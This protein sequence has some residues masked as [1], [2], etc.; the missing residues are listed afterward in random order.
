MAH[1]LRHI[2]SKFISI[3]SIIT[4]RNHVIKYEKPNLYS[5]DI[6]LEQYSTHAKFNESEE[7]VPKSLFVKVTDNRE[8]SSDIVTKENVFHIEDVDTIRKHLISSHLKFSTVRP[9]SQDHELLFCDPTEPNKPSP[10]KLS[11]V[12][13]VLMN[14]LPNFFTKTMDYSIYHPELVFEN[15]IRGTTTVGLY[16]YV[17][18]L[19][20]LRTVAHLK[21]AYVNFEVLK[22]TKHPED[23][24]IKVRWR[25]RGISALKVMVTFWKYK[26]WNFREIFDK[27]E[28]WYDGFST[29]HV[30][31]KG[32]V[33]KHVADKMMPDS[34][35]APA[36][37][38]V[39]PLD[40]AK[41]ALIT[42]LI[43]KFTDI[44]S[45]T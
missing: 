32:E 31:T 9:T 40:T 43:P 34:D 38:P 11:H 25:I 27:T 41:L 10:D 45:I 19:A 35:R 6:C 5:K 29:F 24:T 37:V 22:I 28:A 7:F 42:G 13:D 2:T 33:Y 8:C 44:Y 17:K 14:N 16:H 18:Q 3:T 30:N 26:L 1:C 21:Y 23:S 36:K 39:T 12:Y 15:N 20:L 4:P